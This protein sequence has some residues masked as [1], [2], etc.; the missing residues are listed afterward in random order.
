VSEKHENPIF[1]H[2]SRKNAKFLK[3]S[4]EFPPEIGIS[5]RIPSKMQKIPSKMPKLQEFY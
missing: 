4:I 2:K 3:K 1:H 5:P